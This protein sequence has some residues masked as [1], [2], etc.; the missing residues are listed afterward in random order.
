MA[1][2]FPNL[3]V[4]GIGLSWNRKNS[5]CSY[6]YPFNG[7]EKSVSYMISQTENGVAINRPP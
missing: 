7:E 5:A 1:Q 6:S 2:L 4:I 3:M